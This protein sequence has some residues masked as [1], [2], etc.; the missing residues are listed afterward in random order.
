MCFFIFF[1]FVYSRLKGSDEENSELLKRI[2]AT[3]RLF[4]ISTRFGGQLVL[5]FAAGS[6]LCKEED[7]ERAWQTILECAE[8]KQVEPEQA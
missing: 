7:I 2:T 4:I 8:Q 6:A 1:I 5:R 3:R